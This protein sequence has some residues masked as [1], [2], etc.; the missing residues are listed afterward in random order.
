M[1]VELDDLCLR[2]LVA[3]IVFFFYFQ[4]L[5]P[6]A[7]AADGQPEVQGVEV[8]DLLP[9]TASVGCLGRWRMGEDTGRV[10]HSQ[11]L[12]ATHHQGYH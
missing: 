9:L 10:I 11:M 4:R 5:A 7:E 1:A 6:A 12:T 8:R 3:T 2:S